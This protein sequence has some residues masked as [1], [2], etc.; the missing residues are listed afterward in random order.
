MNKTEL[1]SAILTNLM[2]GYPIGAIGRKPFHQDLMKLRKETP[3]VLLAH[4]K[5]RART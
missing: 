2:P 5:Q 1:V 3:V 4:F